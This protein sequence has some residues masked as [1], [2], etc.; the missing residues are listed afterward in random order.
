MKVGQG[1]VPVRHAGPVPLSRGLAVVAAVLVWLLVD[2]SAWETGVLV[3]QSWGTPDPAAHG[4]GHDGEWLGHAWVDGRKTQHDVE[5]LA[6]AVRTTGIHDLFVHS[7]PFRDDG[8][9]DPA[10]VPEARWF[11][12]AVH[13]RLPGVRVQA[14]LGAHPVPGQLKRESA[15][16]TRSVGQILDDGFDGVHLDFEPVRD[17]DP[18]LLAVLDAA[19]A[20]TRQRHV[21]LS[22]SASYLAPVPGLAALASDLPTPLGVWSAGYLHE[23]A[24][25]VDQVAVMAYDTWLPTTALYTGYVRQ[26]TATAL[27]V[28]PGTVSLFV[29]VPAYHESNLRHHD[30]AETMAA[31][32]RGVRLGLGGHPSARTFGVAV[33]VD[34]TATPDDWARYREWAGP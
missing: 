25:R 7:G 8:T 29:G 31:A 28:T 5:V 23:V 3:A 22:V 10:L 30:G 11:V 15:A 13:A 32:L 21:L 14:W 17:G 19:R 20:V 24:R 1:G 26:L 16:L 2:L 9:L 4:T 33:Y 12:D 6:A 27:D 18:D 34:F